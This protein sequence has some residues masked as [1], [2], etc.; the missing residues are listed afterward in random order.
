MN[1]LRCWAWTRPVLMGNGPDLARLPKLWKQIAAPRSMC[2]PDFLPP[3]SF[4]RSLGDSLL[5]LGRIYLL[6]TLTLVYIP[7]PAV[8]AAL[9]PPSSSS[10]PLV[11]HSLALSPFR[12][13]P[14]PLGFWKR[15]R[16]L[17][18]PRV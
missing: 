13:L 14:R 16:R 10:V 17:S 4:L 8:P 18:V 15:V 5:R 6:S 2:N 11:C 7:P 9:F 1:P 12:L 3:R